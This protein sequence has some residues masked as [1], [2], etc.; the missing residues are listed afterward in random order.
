[1]ENPIKMDYLGG[2]PLFLETSIYKI[3]NEAQHKTALHALQRLY[4]PSVSS[5]GTCDGP[6]KVY[7]LPCFFL[8]RETT[9][10]M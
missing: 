1:M 4:V 8:V 9:E 7:D 6:L 3:E 10:I 2:P 5:C